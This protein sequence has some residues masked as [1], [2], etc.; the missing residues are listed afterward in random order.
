MASELSLKTPSTGLVTLSPADTATDKTITLP[1]TTGTM[2]VQ[3]GTNTTTLT[4]VSYSGTLTGGTGVVNIGS[5]Q[6]YKDASG[7]VGIGV[8]PS[9]W[10]GITSV[11]QMPGGASIFGFG[12][13]TNV[14]SNTYF[15]GGY[16]YVATAAA[17]RYELQYGSHLW[18]TA[19]SG[20][21]GN[22]ISFTQ[23]MTLDSS[24]S[25]LL[26]T[27]SNVGLKLYSYKV[28]DNDQLNSRF[29]TQNTA[30]TVVTYLDVGS[31]PTNNTCY[32]DATG[33]NGASMLFR[34]G[35]SERARIDANG[36]F[37]LNTTTRLYSA[38]ATIRSVNTYTLTSA[39]TG[40]GADGHFVFE[41][42]NGAVGTIFTSGTGTAYNTTSDYRLKNNPQPM[43]GALEFIRRQRPVTYTWKVDG[44]L[45]MG[46]IA[47]WL[48]EDGAGQCVTG[49]KDAV[50]EDGKPQYQG[51][52]SSFMVAPLNAAIKELADIVDR[53]TA[54]LEV[55][56]NK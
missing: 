47:H 48:Q 16:K 53:L 35:G 26:G 10:S 8:T 44:S 20:T 13:G 24:G 14:L 43:T 32:F 30:N 51:V 17:S 5:G 52:D 50:G 6:V 55:L 49:M 36:A 27:T 15:N 45:A 28:G 37:L 41:N 42:A 22:A 4:N 40:T 1:A 9:A 31:N 12:N 39:R 19:P 33:S 29:L 46:Y 23:A 11:L 21:A 38:I 3:D 56:E 2:V 34:T 54:R 25:L 18:F 7:N